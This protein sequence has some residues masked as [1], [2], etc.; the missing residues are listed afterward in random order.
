MI[1]HLWHVYP[2]AYYRRMF[3]AHLN[4]HVYEIIEQTADHFHWDAGGEKWGDIREGISTRTLELGGGHAHVGG[5]IYLGDN[6][7]APYRGQIFT[8]NLHGN[9]INVDKVVREGCGYVGKHAPDFM[10]SQD[11]WFRGIDLLTG[12]DGGVFV[13]DWSD[14]G[15]CHDNDGVHRTSGR[16]FKLVHG[17]PRGVEGFDLS[18]QTSNDLVQW[19]M[20]AND[21]WCRQARRLLQERA[22]AGE[23]MTET[24]RK[25]RNLLTTS[26]DVPHQLRLLWALHACGGTSEKQL[27]ALLGEESEHLRVWAIKLLDELP[28]ISDATSETLVKLAREEQSGLVRG[29]LAS[30]LQKLPLAQ[31][32]SLAMALASHEKDATDRQ[33]PLLVWYGIEPAVPAD[34][35]KAVELVAQSK[36]PMLTTLVARRI[37]GEIERQPVAIESLLALAKKSQSADILRGLSAALQGWSKAPKP[38]NW[39]DVSA[40]LS[41]DESLSLPPCA[42][43][44]LCLAVDARWRSC[45]PSRSGMTPI[46]KRVVPR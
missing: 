4:P 25:L 32:W 15:E 35:A 43:S 8:C 13:L 12:P 16:I 39:D 33:Q 6:W 45:S 42:V 24:R 46:R 29:F 22:A 21:W 19:Q 44:P 40:S 3:G 10:I 20:H 2:G 31:R 26:D 38:A 11:K 14:A 1:G 27:A 30:H 36:L 41:K 9:R 37:G 23:N 28:A 34:P 7:P 18:K 5:M 17:E